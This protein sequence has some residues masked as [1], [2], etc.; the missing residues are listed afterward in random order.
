[1]PKLTPELLDYMMNNKESALKALE[2]AHRE[3]INKLQ[4]NLNIL[5]EKGI[6]NKTQ[7][8]KYNKKQLAEYISGVITA[9][10]EI[11]DDDTIIYTT[12]DDNKYLLKR[13]DELEKIFKLKIMTVQETTKF[14]K[15]D[16]SNK[17]PDY[18]G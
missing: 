4:D 11:G 1:M 10:D 3:A 16:I 8:N 18:I 9:I 17:R 5:R 2:E 14:V 6:I 12:T 7:A 15:N 13:R